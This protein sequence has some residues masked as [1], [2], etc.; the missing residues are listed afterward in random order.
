MTRSRSKPERPRGCWPACRTMSISTQETT[1]PSSP[2]RPVKM[3]SRSFAPQ[4]RRHNRRR[5]DRRGVVDHQAASRAPSHRAHGARRLP[6]RRS[7]DGRPGRDRRRRD[8]RRGGRGTRQDRSR[9]WR[10]AASPGFQAGARHRH[11]RRQHR[12]RLAHRGFASGAD[13]P[14]RNARTAPSRRATHACTR[15]LLSRLRTPGPCCRRDPHPHR[16]A[17]APRRRTLPLLQDL[18]TLRPGHLG[19]ARGVPVPHPQ[20]SYRRCPHRVRGHG[21]DP[22]TRTRHRARRR[23]PAPARPRLVGARGRHPRG[24]LLAHRRPPRERRLPHARGAL[25]ASQGARRDRRSSDVGDSDHRIPRAGT[26]RSGR[27]NATGSGTRAP[28]FAPEPPR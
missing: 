12:Q 8:L 14:G 23:R 3:R 1:K 22:E 25:P 18:E 9:R 15:G 6:A 20:G 24:G 10:N 21:G 27:P 2:H 17:E 5:C 13:R 19:A 7:G 26:R 4:P 16:R 28:V 11:R